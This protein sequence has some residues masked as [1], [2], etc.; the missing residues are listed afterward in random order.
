MTNAG[1]YIKRDWYEKKLWNTIFGVPANIDGDCRS[2]HGVNNAGKTTLIEKLAKRF[3]QTEH[4]CVYYYYTTVAGKE[5]RW[6]FWQDLFVKMQKD[7]TCECMEKAPNPLQNE[8]ELVLSAFKWFSER[9][10]SEIE[11]SAISKRLYECVFSNL[12]LMGFKIILVIDEFDMCDVMC[13]KGDGQFFIELFG[14]SKKA[15]KGQ[16]HSVILVSRRHVKTIEHDMAKG[17]H[18]ADAYEDILLQGF[19][20]SE[21]QRYF[22]SYADLECG[23]LNDDS[24]RDVIYYC[25]RNPG[26]LVTMRE[27]IG[28]YFDQYGII[29]VHKAAKKKMGQLT[30]SYDRMITLMQEEPIVISKHGLS[31]DQGIRSDLYGS[32][33][34]CFDVFVEN[35]IGPITFEESTHKSYMDHLRDCGFAL[36][37]DKDDKQAEDSF[38]FASLLSMAGLCNNDSEEVYEPLCLY[39][40]EHIRNRH[41]ESERYRLAWLL[42]TAECRLRSAIRNQLGQRFGDKWEE[43][44]VTE[45]QYYSFITDK[46]RYLTMLQRQIAA[47]NGEARGITGSILDVLSFSDYYQIAR[48]FGLI[49]FYCYLDDASRQSSF[50]TNCRNL[51]AHHNFRVLD[52]SNAKHLG[53]LCEDLIKGIEEQEFRMEITPNNPNDYYGKIVTMTETVLLLPRR[54]MAGVI[55]GTK[56]RV[57]LPP[58]E[59][60]DIN[61]EDLVGQDLQ[62]KIVKWDPNQANPHFEATLIIE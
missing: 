53:T 17:S 30:S 16:H 4:P 22:D 3:N 56:Y 40:V 7:F 49:G 25:G 48:K 39:L 13:K 15:G 36:T 9:D 54:N 10:L 32:T 27:A 42:D 55:L 34:W 21:M 31:Y 2:L 52:A 14:L 12:R 43:S 45:M 35:F 19:N 58:R 33:I 47:N 41:L 24:K 11:Q 62:V 59:L 23:V 46:G 6:D 18:L 60:T 37:Y 50:L 8:R 29:D 51:H 44:L 26:L 20:N 57:T 1:L 5:S 61:A 28:D 38:H